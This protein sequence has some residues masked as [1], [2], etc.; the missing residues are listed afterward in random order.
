M[1]QV[2][3]AFRNEITPGNFIFRTREFEQ[4]EIEYFIKPGTN[5]EWHEKWKADCKKF[6]I[7]TL[8]IKEENLK[9][10]NHGKDE[11]SFYSNATTDVEYLFP[12]GWGELWGIADRTDYDLKAHM[13]ESKADLSYFDPYDNTK[14]IPHVI[15]PSVGL[16]RLF[17]ATLC[18]SYDEVETEEG[19]RVVMRFQPSVAPVKVAVL[20][21]VKKLS[22]EAMEIFNL[23]SPHFVCDY[24]ET[25][26]IGKRYFRQDE[27]GTPFAIAVDGENFAA[28][29]VTVRH[30]DTGLQDVVKISE[31][32]EWVRQRV[33]A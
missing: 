8:G 7:E 2:G 6:L 31:L 29:Q 13:K 24:D 21:I 33:M 10:R 30:R 15:E 20:P 28:G 22:A 3:K 18:D 23:L 32:V 5:L 4:M 27:I 25:G 11:L 12:N 9:F 16:T 14:F 17:L 1:A 26:A 19:K